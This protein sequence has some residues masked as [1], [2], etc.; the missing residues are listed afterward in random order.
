MEKG[1]ELPNIVFILSDDQGEWALGCTGNPLIKTPNLD[2]LAQTGVL[3]SNFF[4]ASPVCSPARASLLTGKIP[5]QHG[6]HDWIRPESNTEERLEYLNEHVGYTDILAENNYTCGISGKWHLGN[7]S[8]LQKSFSHWY[9]L[10]YGGGPYNDPIMIRD[11]KEVQESGYLTDLITDD[12]I[13][14]IEKQA[15]R[16]NPFYL[17]VHYTAPHSPWINQHPQEYLDL[18]DERILDYFPKNER[19]PWSTTEYDNNH[20]E[21]LRGYLASITAMDSNIGRI[22]DKLD[23][24]GIRENTLVCFLGDNGFNFGHHGIWGKGNG[25]FPQNMFDTSI[26]VPAILN[27]PGQLPEGIV[28][29][30]LVSGYDFMP[31][32]LEY[33]GIKYS[34][35]GNLPGRS[36]LGYLNE[37]KA[38]TEHRENIVIFDE[39]GPVRMI[40]TKEWKYIHRYPY[41]PHELYNLKDD[42]NE[43]ENL[44]ENPDMHDIIKSMK[45][46]LEAWFTTYTNP[47]VDGTKEPVYGAG[48]SGLL[49][50][51]GDGSTVFFEWDDRSKEVAR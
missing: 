46:N 26:K 48:Q 37:A 14:F 2:R 22:L 5:S 6:V 38:D 12:S 24:L 40:R 33:V 9:V 45:K 23:E 41:G 47:E 28:C 42:P 13:A 29:D 3:F 16:P 39:Y 19:H 7:S 34:E 1:K 21:N 35:I 50:N 17:S 31:T 25:T 18:Y 11:G 27:H 51:K 49:G 10:P 30:E 15:L 43:E 36:F 8:S 44:F 4:C 32:L 20:F